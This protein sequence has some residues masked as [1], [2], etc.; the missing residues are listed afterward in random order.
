MNNHQRPLTSVWS[1]ILLALSIFCSVASAETPS[2]LFIGNSYTYGNDLDQMSAELLD[3]GAPSW[4]GA[5][6]K[7]HAQGGARLTQ[8]LA[9]ADGTQGDTALRAYLL[10]P[11]FTAVVLQEQSQIP[12]FPQDNELYLESSDA[13]MG[14]NGLITDNGAHTLALMTWGKRSGDPDNF[15]RYP[16]FKAMQAHLKNGYFQYATRATTPERSV[17]VIPAGLA[18]EKIYDDIVAAGEDPLHED[19]LFWGLYSADG[20]HL[21]VEGT[22]L[23]ACVAFASLTGES[24]AGTNWAPDEVR[25]E[26]RETLQEAAAVVVL[27]HE[28]LPPFTLGTPEPE[29]PEEPVTDPTEE[30]PT[31]DTPD[32]DPSDSQPQDTAPPQDDSPAQS[33]DSSGCSSIPSLWL[34]LLLAITV[35]LRRR[36]RKHAQ[37]GYRAL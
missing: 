37:V 29:E 22:Y 16:S 27:N 13:F 8:H 2:L 14:L 7:R 15:F 9:A 5:I 17:V 32:T 20:S 24:P 11:A 35:A 26:V 30:T 1:T 23:V 3:A 4:S 25:A 33:S 10:G 18:F 19:S 34:W 6:A 12:G 36:G 21:S 28:E 31:E